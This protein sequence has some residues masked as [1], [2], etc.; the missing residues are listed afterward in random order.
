[1]GSQMN[2]Q[3]IGALESASKVKDMLKDN[4]YEVP[5]E[6][7][8]GAFLCSLINGPITTKNNRGAPKLKGPKFRTLLKH[9]LVFS[10]YY[11]EAWILSEKRGVKKT[12]VIRNTVKKFAC[13]DPQARNGLSVSESLLYSVV[14]QNKMNRVFLYLLGTQMKEK[15]VDFKS[16]GSKSELIGFMKS[17][18]NGIYLEWLHYPRS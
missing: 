8:L 9:L 3:F 7:L 12:L 13:V 2:T 14:K 10:V 6:T 17:V 16:I 15:N 11:T 1:M 5:F 4:G 18:C